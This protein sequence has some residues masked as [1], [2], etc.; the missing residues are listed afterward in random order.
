MDDERRPPSPILVAATAVV[1]T[2]AVLGVFSRAISDRRGLVMVLAATSAS[3][4]MPLAA[5]TLVL[6]ASRAK[7]VTDLALVLP[8]VLSV[9][10]LVVALR[11]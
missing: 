11:P 4:L 8:L 5:A 7:R 3:V 9:V 2:L 10:A 6:A 1:A